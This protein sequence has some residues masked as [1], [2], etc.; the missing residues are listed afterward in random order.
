MTK[1]VLFNVQSLSE[2]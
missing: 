2:I 1:S